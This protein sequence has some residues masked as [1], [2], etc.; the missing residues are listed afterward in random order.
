MV[1]FSPPIFYYWQQ[2][3]FSEYFYCHIHFDPSI[4]LFRVY[5]HRQSFYFLIL[6]SYQFLSTH[7]LHEIRYDR[8]DPQI[9]QHL[10]YHW[11]L[12]VNFYDLSLFH[13]HCSDHFILKNLSCSYLTQRYN[14]SN[15]IYFYLIFCLQITFNDL[16]LYFENLWTMTVNLK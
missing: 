13:F 7:L 9:F 15:F 8:D 14:Y 5:P 16:N 12:K 10:K 6:I 4:K 3:P 11:T 2:T 1:L